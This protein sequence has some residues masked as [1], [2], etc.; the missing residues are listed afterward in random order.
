MF[1]LSIPRAERVGRYDRADRFAHKDVLDRS[2]VFFVQFGMVHRGRDAEL[3]RQVLLYFERVLD[4]GGVDNARAI[5][6]LVA[7][8]EHVEN[9]E[10][11][12]FFVGFTGFIDEIRPVEPAHDRLDLSIPN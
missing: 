8:E 7:G 10:L 11:I 6:S 12:G 2:A 3:L 5:E 1:G 4:R 9:L